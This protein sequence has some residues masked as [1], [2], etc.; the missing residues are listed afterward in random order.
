MR[1]F[2]RKRGSL[3]SGAL[4]GP[5]RVLYGRPREKPSTKKLGEV[6]DA[7][8]RHPEV[9]AAFLT[10]RFHPD[11]YET[12]TLVLGLSLDDPARASGIFQEIGDA[13]H[14]LRPGDKVL[15]FEIVASRPNESW[16][17]VYRR[18]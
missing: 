12:P 9:E 16:I 18:G 1:L 14:P 13:V 17:S 10:Q 8:A 4:S 11:L 2:R 15:D 6:R 3:F 5:T 7:C